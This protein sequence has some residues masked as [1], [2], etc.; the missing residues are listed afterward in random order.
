MHLSRLTATSVVKKAKGNNPNELFTV[1][2]T[3]AP[4]N[5]STVKSE[6]AES[7]KYYEYDIRT[8]KGQIITYQ[9]INGG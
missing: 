8:K 9:A 1:F 4:I 3:A 6:N 2:A 7:K 5:H